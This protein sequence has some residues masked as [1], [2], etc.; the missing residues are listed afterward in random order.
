M[1]CTYFVRLAANYI[2]ATC[3]VKVQNS[4]Q[5]LTMNHTHTVHGKSLFGTLAQG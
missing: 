3:L 4:E 1:L 2:Q 5:D